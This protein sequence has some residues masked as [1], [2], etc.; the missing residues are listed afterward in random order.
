MDTVSIRSCTFTRPDLILFS[1]QVFVIVI[2]ICV[3]LF[4]LSFDKSNSDL[5]TPILMA[6]IGYILPN[7]KLKPH[8]I[9]DVSDSSES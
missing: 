2:V 8:N 6:S 5:W 1:C 4:N 9:K 3:S 7:P